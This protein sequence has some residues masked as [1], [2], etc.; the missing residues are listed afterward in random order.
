[1]LFGYTGASVSW[2]E[3]RISMKVLA[4]ILAIL[5]ILTAVIPQFGDCESQGKM[6]TLPN[7]KQVSMKCHWSARA[8]IA[9]G[10][11]LL[12]VAGALG[13][14]RRKET[15]R[16]LTLVGLLL[17]ALV[18]AIPNLLIGVC[19]GPDMTCRVILYPAT[20]LLGGLIIV[21]SLVGFVWNE[22][23]AEPQA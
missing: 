2:M 1:M 23:K 20:L 5:A 16:A 9:M 18:I 21:G 14:S 10:I 12:G 15:R 7:G 3:R 6:L 22:V 19:S 4:V 8:E 11:P 13:F 17:G